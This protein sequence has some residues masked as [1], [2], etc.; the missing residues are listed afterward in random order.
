MAKSSYRQKAARIRN[1]NKRRLSAVEATLRNLTSQSPK[2][3]MPHDYNK[4]CQATALISEVIKYWD[5]DFISKRD[6]AYCK[7]VAKR[8]Y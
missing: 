2:T 8:G 7:A 6:D 5:K 1:F 3:F 4:L